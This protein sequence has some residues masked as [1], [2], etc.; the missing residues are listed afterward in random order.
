MARDI[1]FEIHQGL[2]REG[3][4]RNKYTRR[5]FQML[6]PLETPHILDIGCGPGGPTVELARLS[7]GH[8]IG[9]DIHQSYLDELVKR[10]KRAGLSNH[11]KARNCSMVEMDFPDESFDIIW[12]EGSIFV[13]GFERGLREWRRFIKPHEFLAVHE[14]TWLRP[15]PPQ[16][17]SEYWKRLYSDTRTVQENLERIPRCGYDLIGHFTLPEDA[18]WTEYY[19]PLELRLGQLSSKYA[20]DPEALEVLDKEQDEIDMYRKS[21]QWYGSAFFVMRKR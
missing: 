10:A 18:W 20:D 11:V 17:I 15:D 2:P 19:G 4:G 13:I 8:V 16:E 7:Q 12:A 21:R 1:F 14:V 6:P 9:L 3:P 5:A